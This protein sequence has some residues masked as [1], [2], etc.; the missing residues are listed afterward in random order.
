[1]I[2]FL[3]LLGAFLTMLA[4]WVWDQWDRTQGEDK[5]A[6]YVYELLRAGMFW[7]FFIVIVSVVYGW[8]V[9][10]GFLEKQILFKKK[11]K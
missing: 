2:A 3:Y 7:P 4:Y 9:L 8:S 11:V 6:V 1:V 5:R 10:E